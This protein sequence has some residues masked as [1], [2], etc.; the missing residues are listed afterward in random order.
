MAT[1]SEQYRDLIQRSGASRNGEAA[2]PVA[3]GASAAA[4]QT[5]KDRQKAA[6]GR[7][8]KQVLSLLAPTSRHAATNPAHPHHPN[9][10]G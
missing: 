8:I 9:R 3:T 10:R 1:R 7:K 2:H 5:R 4:G 6:V